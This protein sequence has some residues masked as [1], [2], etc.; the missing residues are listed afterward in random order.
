MITLHDLNEAHLKFANT[1]FEPFLE[2]NESLSK[3]LKKYYK[4]ND[5]KNDI[6]L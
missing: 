3:L 6:L 2:E 5:F 1:K 4:N